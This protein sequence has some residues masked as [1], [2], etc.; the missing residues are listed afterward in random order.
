M[1]RFRTALI[2]RLGAEW[3]DESL[4]RHIVR[5]IDPDTVRRWTTVIPAERLAESSLLTYDVPVH[6]GEIDA[7]LV[8]AFGHR[9]PDT[10]RRP[11]PV[12]EGLAALVTAAAL[13]PSVIV[14]AQTE[15]AAVLRRSGAG[16][17]TEIELERRAD[18]SVR[19]QSTIDVT[20]AVVD[21]RGGDAASFG[22]VAVVAFA[23]HLGRCIL[24]ARAAGLDA[25][26]SSRFGV[27]DEYD[28]GSTQ[29]WTRSR[30][31]YL[32]VDLM[33]RFG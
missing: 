15:P 25:V 29:P 7:V 18:G 22:T 23:D 11:G 27:V 12:N 4:A 2:E 32:A 9:G 31:A 16:Q 8:F 30:E 5:S 33:A 24:A 1:E 10:D 20:R 3:G 13:P 6:G 26:R 17:V 28:S 21:R 14:L 19:Y